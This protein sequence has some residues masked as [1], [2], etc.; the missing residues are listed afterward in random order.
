ML[1]IDKRETIH[2]KLEKLGKNL[3]DPKTFPKR[4]SATFYGTQ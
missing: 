3:Q 4:F 1:K 2:K